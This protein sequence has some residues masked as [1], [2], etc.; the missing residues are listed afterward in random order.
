MDRRRFLT[1]SGTLMAAAAPVGAVAAAPASG[2][3]AAG[4]ETLRPLPH[5]TPLQQYRVGYTSNTRGGWEGDPWKGIQEAREVG[6]RY[7]EIFGTSFSARPANAPP[8]QPARPDEPAET[9]VFYPDDWEHLQRRMFE[10]GAQFVSITG[11]RQGGSTAFHDPAQRE[12]VIENHF[13]M[14][15]FSRRFGNDVW[16]TNLGSRGSRDPTDAEI[17]E[18]AITCNALGRR[19]KEELGMRLAIHPHVG[20]QLENEKETMIIMENTNPEWVGLTLDTGHI[21]MAG[22]DPLGLFKKLGKRVLEFH[23]KDVAPEHAKGA[24]QVPRG[25]DQMTNPYFLPLGLG[26]IDFLGIKAECDRIGWRGF[27]NVELDTS[28]WRTPK[29]SAR[30]SA[31][32][33]KDVL[34]IE[35]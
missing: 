14:A 8:R 33:V 19:M 13:S 23:L 34:K 27:Y 15:R 7:F 2:R 12:A 32:Y 29:E 5:Y 28:P 1:A 25:I 16:K 26:G 35:L 20:N 4:A 9:P 18:M 22:M 10:L 21:A 3:A 24:A 17:R 31:S 6:F 11:G 30:I